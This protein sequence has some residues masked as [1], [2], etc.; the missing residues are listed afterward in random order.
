MKAGVFF[1]FFTVYIAAL[2]SILD[3]DLKGGSGFK[4]GQRLKCE[5]QSGS[6]C[7]IRSD[8]VLVILHF[9]VFQMVH[10]VFL[11]SVIKVTYIIITYLS[12]YF[13][14]NHRFEVLVLTI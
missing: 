7:K 9:H 3:L 12:H 2:L 4:L 6:K 10:L 11:Y 14:I 13:Q 1:Y 5:V 8:P